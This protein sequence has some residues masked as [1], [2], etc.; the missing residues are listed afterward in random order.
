M[1]SPRITF[2]HF[3]FRELFL[4]FFAPWISTEKSGQI[5]LRNFGGFYIAPWGPK[6]QIISV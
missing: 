4:V 1:Q 5:I 3:I 2:D 6:T